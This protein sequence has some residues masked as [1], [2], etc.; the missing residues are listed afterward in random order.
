METAE[1]HPWDDEEEDD[2]GTMSCAASSF[3]AVTCQSPAA[4]ASSAESPMASAVS[5][6]GGGEVGGDGDDGGRGVSGGSGGGGGGGNAGETDGQLQRKVRQRT[7][8]RCGFMEGGEGWGGGSIPPLLPRCRG[9]SDEKRKSR[10]CP[11]A[12]GGPNNEQ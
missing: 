10:T 11:P 6:D 7:T 5:R 12:V 4:H 8:D 3:S 1:S 9:P 2:D